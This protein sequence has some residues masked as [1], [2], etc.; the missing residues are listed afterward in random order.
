MVDVA[1]QEPENFIIG[2]T[3]KWKKSLS[4]YKASDSWVLKYAA[5]GPGTINITATATGDDHEIN[6]SAA[7]TGAYTAGTYKWAASVEKDGEKFTI[8]E[9][10]WEVKAN[11]AT[12]TSASDRML[13]LPAD[14]D[15]INQFLGKNYK[16][17]SYSIA[18]RSLN[19]YSIAELFTLRDRL[20]RELNSLKDAEK[21]RRGLGTKKLI[22]VRF[23]P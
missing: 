6:L 12:A 1:T 15:A 10:Y 14:I 18:G 9:G 21:I 16:Y 17:S 7:T 22:R 19:N 3:V 20:Q 5:R 2:D 4:D 8:E 11:L 13:A 23:N